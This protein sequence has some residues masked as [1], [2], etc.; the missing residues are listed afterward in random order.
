MPTD[1]SSSVM[2]V[3][4]YPETPLE[5]SS[6]NWIW[7]QRHLLFKRLIL[8]GASKSYIK[9]YVS[10]LS[11]RISNTSVN[12]VNGYSVVQATGNPFIPTKLYNKYLSIIVNFLASFWRRKYLPPLI[13]PFC[14]Y[15]I[16][17]QNKGKYFE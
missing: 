5:C 9:Q 13:I 15:F 2:A 14:L 8:F 11:L 17:Q 16:I 1:F 4:S 10:I 6:K 3:T 12:S 7:C